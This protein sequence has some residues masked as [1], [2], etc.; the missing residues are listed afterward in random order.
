MYKR[1]EIVHN[2][3][4]Y[5]AAICDYS[6]GVKLYTLRVWYYSGWV[7]QEEFNRSYKSLSSAKNKLKKYFKGEKVEWK[8]CEI[9]F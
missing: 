9:I 6:C 2:G 5:H 1:F 4:I 7:R 8:E 3:A